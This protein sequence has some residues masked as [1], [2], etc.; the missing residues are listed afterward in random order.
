MKFL[1][2][3]PTSIPGDKFHGDSTL[4]I[5]G[6]VC[7][8]PFPQPQALWW[9][10]LKKLGHEVHSIPYIGTQWPGL[11]LPV[12]VARLA[13]VLNK[14]LGQMSVAASMHLVGTPPV[15]AFNRY[16]VSM[17]ESIRPDVV[18]ISGGVLAL[19]KETIRQFKNAGAKC[20][21]LSG[22]PIATHPRRNEIHFAEYMDLICVND[23]M[24]A[25]DW[26]LCGCKKV[27]CLPVSACDPEFHKDINGIGSVR[28]QR[29][30]RVS[31]V[32]SF[33]PDFYYGT[34]RMEYLNAVSDLNLEI[35]SGSNRALR[36]FPGLLKCYKGPARHSDIPKIISDSA[37]NINILAR[38]MP[39]GGNYRTFEIAGCGGFQLCD[40]FLDEW[41][42]EGKEIIRF[43]SPS[44]LREKV[45]FYLENEDLRCEIAKRGEKRAHEDH[46]FVKR[47][48][49]IITLLE[50]R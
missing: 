38:A 12:S 31:F 46:T 27:V 16:V 8:I 21:L 34:D 44:D 11:P 50:G 40:H 7:P 42:E 29:N 19:T 35:Y 14:R 24:H 33:E 15:M 30:R 45:L 39:I 1:L 22:V 10:A 18:L 4:C 2:I 23:P 48:G 36:D 5:D 26:Q 6:D 37:I 43:S 20:V 13:A 47:F 17:F 49:S 25:V 28:T 3:C 32:G 41:F 9:K